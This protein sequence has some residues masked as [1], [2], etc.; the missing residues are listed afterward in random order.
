[1]VSLTFQTRARVRMR[2][3]V[4]VSLRTRLLSRSRCLLPEVSLTMRGDI[5]LVSS[6]VLTS[7]CFL[8][9]IGAQLPMR[10]S[11]CRKC[12]TRNVMVVE[13]WRVLFSKPSVVSPQ[14]CRSRSR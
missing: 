10:A 11:S 8:V 9:S 13:R 14:L 5:S 4:R 6:T 3:R 2:V 12:Y 7:G 1:M